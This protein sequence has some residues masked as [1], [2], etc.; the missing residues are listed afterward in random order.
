MLRTETGRQVNPSDGCR[1]LLCQTLHIH[2]TVS[3][4]SLGNHSNQ[5]NADGTSATA[6]NDPRLR[7]NVDK[8][9]PLLYY[10]VDWLRN[11]GAEWED[12]A[13]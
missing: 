9:V 13:R 11:G 1:R 4:K 3:V 7:P 6:A 8:P 12:A 2:P 10:I 5:Q